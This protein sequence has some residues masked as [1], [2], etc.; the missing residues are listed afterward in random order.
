MYN[1]NLSARLHIS[2]IA[3]P[4]IRGTLLV[5]QELSIF[6]SIVV[7]FYIAYGTRFIPSE[8]AWR[9]RFCIEMEISSCIWRVRSRANDV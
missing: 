2:K 9:L 4:E 8:W 5:M 6:T 1:P 7:A 3:P